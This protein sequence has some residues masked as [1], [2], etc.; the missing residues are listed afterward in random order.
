MNKTKIRNTVII[1][2]GILFLFIAVGIIYS[3]N[4]AYALSSNVVVSDITKYDGS[5]ITFTGTDTI[6]FNI[7]L[8]NQS[9][10]KNFNYIV[11]YNVSSLASSL[12]GKTV[13]LSLEQSTD[14]STW[15]T[16]STTNVTN[17]D[18]GTTKTLKAETPLSSMLTYF[19]VT[20]LVNGVK[21]D[22]SGTS[23]RGMLDVKTTANKDIEFTQVDEYQTFTAPVDGN[24]K[25]QLW[26]AS[27]NSYGN[28][29]GINSGKGAYTD[30]IIHLTKGTTLYVYTG[31][32]ATDG[33]AWYEA[34]FGG[35]GAGGGLARA[36]SNSARIHYGAS[37]GGASD[38]RLVNGTYDN[39]SSLNSRIM[40]AAGG[41]G[42]LYRTE[43]G[44]YVSGCAGTGGSG[45]GLVGYQGQIASIGLSS[46]NSV[47][48]TVINRY[49]TG[50][51]QV[52]GG[53]VGQIPSGAYLNNTLNC[54]SVIQYTGIFGIGG[55]GYTYYGSTTYVGSSGG[56]GG[57]YGGTGGAECLTKPSEISATNAPGHTSGAGG[58]SYISG[59]TGSIA[60]TGADNQTPKAGCTESGTTPNNYVGTDNNSCSIHYSGYTFTDTVMIDGEG[61]SWTNTR[62]SAPSNKMPDYNDLTKYF[63]TGNTGSGAAKITLDTVT[64]TLDYSESTWANIE[65]PNIDITADIDRNSD[66]V[67]NTVT[68]TNTSDYNTCNTKIV[69]PI[70]SNLINI[71]DVVMVP[72][73]IATYKLENNTITV[74]FKEQFKAHDTFEITY[75][76]D[77][78]A[79][80]TTIN[81]DP[82]G[83]AYPSVGTTCPSDVL[84]NKD[85]E[86]KK[87]AHD[88][89]TK[90]LVPDTEMFI[91]IGTIIIGL[92]IIGVGYF[93]LL[94]NKKKINI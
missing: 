85:L 13:Q 82:I 49:N 18:V 33:T 47:Q 23:I 70:D 39:I 67:I 61:Y 14:N 10:P 30:G 4:K 6:D 25:V 16:I 17:S 19:R 5:K 24:Y 37:G 59:H 86:I 35:G 76:A 9:V 93:I 57:Y 81:L 94:K 27:G 75:L 45:G 83:T 26:G 21:D 50:G 84:N 43:S 34:S 28:E 2:V 90:V 12:S 58:S 46:N 51:T 64:Q 8:V 29:Q 22:I 44:A 89:I 72:S 92:S 78:I 1:T 52:G 63:A 62:E 54:S 65:T 88:E 20:L 7:E 53:R 36:Q 73:N 55:R 38:V 31:K 74:T 66:G 32:N 48:Q 68:L 80:S 42:S 79:N 56:G 71:R 40:V 60:I 69:I 91:S 77:E 15:S 41:G 87:T 11:T 3:S